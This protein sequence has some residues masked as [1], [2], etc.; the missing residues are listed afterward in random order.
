MSDV[1][2]SQFRQDTDAALQESVPLAPSTAPQ[3]ESNIEAIRM[4]HKARC[5]DHP[6]CA[7]HHACLDSV[8]TF[9]QAVI[10]WVQQNAKKW[11]QQPC[12]CPEYR[13]RSSMG[14]SLLSTAWQIPCG[15]LPE[16]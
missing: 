4:Q 2:Y 5:I 13:K 10:H 15:K 1:D 7:S 11:Y 8:K 14:A 16:L 6:G 9:R 3:Y 12:F